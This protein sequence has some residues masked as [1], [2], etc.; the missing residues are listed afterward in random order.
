M[1]KIALMIASLGIAAT[2]LPTAASAA[3]WQ[4]VNQRQTSIERRIDQGIRTG[5]LDRR[6]AVRLRTELRQISQLENR[7]RRSG[8]GLS[9]SER[10]DLDQRLDRLAARTQVQKHDRNRGHRR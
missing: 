5:Q 6:E 8:G 1:K 4:N 9:V 2:A 7:Y 3:P 10:R